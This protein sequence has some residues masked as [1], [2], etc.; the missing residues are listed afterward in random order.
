MKF[1]QNEFFSG[2]SQSLDMRGTTLTEWLL[3]LSAQLPQCSL[4]SSLGAVCRLGSAHRSNWG[5]CRAKAAFCSSS[6]RDFRLYL[7]SPAHPCG[8]LLS[9]VVSPFLTCLHCEVFRTR[10]CDDSLMNFSLCNLYITPLFPP[11]MLFFSLTCLPHRHFRLFLI[12]N[13]K[14]KCVDC[15]GCSSNKRDNWDRLYVCTNNSVSLNFHIQPDGWS[16]LWLQLTVFISS[17]CIVMF[18]FLIDQLIIQF[19]KCQKTQK[20]TVTGFQNQRQSLQIVHFL[21]QSHNTRI[22][23]FKW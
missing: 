10:L 5:S 12:G 23:N 13:M 19:V 14:R 4:S 2:S 9:F 16:C 11:L 8:V 3:F 15:V 17:K 22:F 20:N 18:S 21:Q 1:K 6:W 7:P